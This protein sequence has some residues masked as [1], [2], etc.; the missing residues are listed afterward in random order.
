MIARSS[1][2]QHPSGGGRPRAQPG[3]GNRERGTVVEARET[4]A[5]RSGG[6]RAAVCKSW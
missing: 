5:V 2:P 6:P 3:A 4:G 1:I